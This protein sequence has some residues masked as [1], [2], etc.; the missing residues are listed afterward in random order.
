MN[1]EQLY[2]I[3]KQHPDV[4]TDSRNCRPGSIFIAL[5]GENFNGNCFVSQAMKTGCAYAVTDEAI[6]ATDEHIILV[7]DCLQTLQQ[8]ARYHRQQ[9]GTPVI[10]ITGTNGKTT[11]KELISQILS[12][13][14]KVLYTQGNLNNHIGVPLTLL[15]L[16]DEH[17]I[18]V[19]EMGAS[20][21]GEIKTLSEI[22]LPDYGLI[23][24]VGK[25]H[26]E[27]FG[28]FEGI[29]KTKGELYDYIRQTGGK[30]FIH[31]EN[32][33][34]NEIAVNIDK[35]FYGHEP[36]LFVWGNVSGLSPLLSMEWYC[37]E[38]TYTID[39]QLVGA[40]NIDNILATIAIGKFLGVTPEN[41]CKAVASYVPQNNR[42]QFKD[43]G[44]NRLIIDAYNANPTSMLAALENFRDIQSTQKALILGDMK[45]LGESSREEHRKIV[46]FISGIS[47]DKVFLC[48]PSFTEAANGIFPVFPETDK[49]IESLQKEPLLGY[50]ILIKGSRG[51]KLEKTIDLL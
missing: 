3:F 40:Y 19:I 33:Y 11:T 50:Q 38:G 37:K 1:T 46:D 48:G 34:L 4:T 41:C 23:T 15:Q 51:M 47:V 45:E 32:P 21:Q 20:H 25:A 26:L 24:N 30:I 13:Q 43:T 35:V 44:R 39:T 49:L 18:A 29:I 42:S 28:S 8:L 5:K 7:D 14:Y 2:S 9:L 10:G 36:D 17:E 22:A 31:H 6:Y 12:T 27:G 16:T